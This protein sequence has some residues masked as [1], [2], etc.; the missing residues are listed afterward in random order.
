MNQVFAGSIVGSP[1]FAPRTVGGPF[2]LPAGH[3]DLADWR[4]AALPRATG[5]EGNAFMHDRRTRGSERATGREHRC[6][7]E[8]RLHRQRRPPRARLALRGR[9]ARAAAA[10]R[11]SISGTPAGRAGGTTGRSSRSSSLGRSSND[12]AARPGTHRVPGRSSVPQDAVRGRRRDELRQVSEPVVTPPGT[13]WVSGSIR[14]ACGSRRPRKVPGVHDLP[15]VAWEPAIGATTYEIQLSRKPYP[16]KARADSRR[17]VNVDRAAAR[18]EGRRHVVLPSPGHQ[19]G[20]ASGRPGDEL[21]G[22]GRD[23]ITGDRFRVVKYREVGS[24]A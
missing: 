23:R 11:A 15:L 22:A 1:A 14:A 10:R 19:P 4:R 17:G 12:P 7:V 8:R 2:A 20:A 21:V 6:E 9:P 5:S 24:A 13:P 16:W 18:Q 3:E